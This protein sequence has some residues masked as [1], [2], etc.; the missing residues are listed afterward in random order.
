MAF[1]SDLYKKVLTRD[2]GAH[3][4][5]YLKRGKVGEFITTVKRRSYLCAEA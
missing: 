4:A 2:I 5:T 1:G 3:E